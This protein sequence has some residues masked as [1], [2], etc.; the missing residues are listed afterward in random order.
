MR[1]KWV[2]IIDSS[3]TSSTTEY[4]NNIDA[5]DTNTISTGP[6]GFWSWDATPRRCLR[7]RMFIDDKCLKKKKAE[8]C[9]KS[10]SLK[11]KTKL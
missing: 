3:T 2:N 10:Y 9:R 6:R 5:N 7:C 4:G 11:K 8:T 1:T